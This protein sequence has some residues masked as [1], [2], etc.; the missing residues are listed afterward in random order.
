MARIRSLKPEFW[1]DSVIVT[2]SPLARLF[3]QGLWNHADE[4]GVLE[5]E[6][7]RL[8]FQ[9]LPAD[10]VDARALLDELAAAGR[11]RRA[12]TADGVRVVVIPKFRKHQKVDARLQPRFGD[13][14]TFD[15]DRPDPPPPVD[16]QPHVDASADMQPHVS[17]G[18]GS[19]DMGQV[20][21]PPS[22][23]VDRPAVE[24]RLEVQLAESLDAVD[25]FEPF[26]QA[27]PARNGKKLHKA[28]AKQQWVRLKPAER[29]RAYE[30]A[31]HYADAYRARLPGVGAMD[32][33]RWLRD[34][35]FDDW[36]TPAV[37]DNVTPLH[38]R[39]D[40]IDAEL[41]AMAR[42]ES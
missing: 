3:F 30:A 31:K 33:F 28:K 2:L 8:K 11:I 36:L 25:D 1:T 38:S 9:I 16:M 21:T 5:D 24:N 39:A 4:W 17:Q 42:G 27:Y 32:G 10:Q 12:V 41:A 18:Q 29:I 35:C 7:E 34:R 37:P 40:R 20:E 23:R 14:A 19:G 13:P 6:P 22:T 26:W 15:Y